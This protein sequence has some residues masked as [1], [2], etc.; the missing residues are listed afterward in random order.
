MKRLLALVL[1]VA[2]ADAF[3]AGQPI[4]QQSDEDLS[5]QAFVQAVE[6]AISTTERER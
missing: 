6:T 1:F 4:P 3:A 2:A 5:I